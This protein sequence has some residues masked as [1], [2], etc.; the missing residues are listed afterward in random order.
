MN[1]AT[2]I[3][4]RNSN[5]PAFATKNPNLFVPAAAINGKEIL[6]N[7]ISAN[8]FISGNTKTMTHE[9]AHTGGLNHPKSDKENKAGIVAP[10]KYNPSNF[11]NQNIDFSP[12]YSK[13]NFTG[14][15]RD[16][17]LRIFTLYSNGNLNS[18]SGTH[19]IDKKTGFNFKT[20][21]W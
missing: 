15:T 4:I 3:E 16:Q 14:P 6:V 18:K 13:T 20:V 10:F 7:E 1:D 11:M 19:P 5:D 21:L 8:S 9:I 2:L 12:P 17:V